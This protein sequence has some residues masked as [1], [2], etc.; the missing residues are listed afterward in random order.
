[1]SLHNDCAKCQHAYSRDVVVGRRVLSDFACEYRRPS[2]PTATGC[3][4]Y[5][6]KKESSFDSS[7][8]EK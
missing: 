4:D 6:A 7:D 1:M 8:T 2:F 3:A 5:D